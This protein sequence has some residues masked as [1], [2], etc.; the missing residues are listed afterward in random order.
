M[1]MRSTQKA[2]GL[3]VCPLAG[4]IYAG[5]LLKDG[6]TLSS[7]RN[8]VTELA[9]KATA[10]HVLFKGGALILHDRHNTPI[11]QITV[12]EVP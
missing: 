10:M 4:D 11:C 5:T 8:D 9:L 3:G 6:K 12:E 2:I 7:H 1:N